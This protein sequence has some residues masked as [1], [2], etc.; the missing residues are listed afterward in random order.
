[1]LSRQSKFVQRTSRLDGFTFLSLVVFNSDSLA[2]ESLNDL[3]TK[4]ELDHGVE[5]TKQALDERFNKYAVNFLKT[6]L[7]KLLQKQLSA[8][9]SLIKCKEFKRIL[10]KDSVC[11][12]VDESMADTYPGSGGSGS[13]AN[14][15][16]QLEYDLLTGKVVDL[17]LNA[18]N[19]QDSVN[20]ML[21]IDV[22][23]D[24]DLIVR[25]LAYMHLKALKKILIRL[26][27]FL[28]RLQTQRKVYQQQ[29]NQLI[30]LDFAE[31]SRNMRAFDIQR[32]E[33]SVFLGED[34]ELQVRLFIYL[35]PDAVYR[36]RMRKLN[37]NAKK[38]GREL[39]A[40]SKARAQLTLFI[41]SAP[42]EAIS[43][44]TA[45]KVYTLRW[46]IELTFKVWKSIWKIDKVKKVKQERLE[47]YIWAKLFIIITSWHV[48]WFIGKMLRQLYG[49]NLS[50]YKAM[51]TIVFYINR[52]RQMI[53]GGSVTT[54]KYLAEF[55]ILS[56]RKHLLEK[57]K[58]ANYSPE[59]LF[60]TFTVSCVG[61]VISV[62]D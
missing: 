30:E 52:F 42:E 40:E 8:P 9:K 44:G 7:E 32:I 58:S 56:R 17:S 49:K 55:L 24:G 4:L 19:D 13:R 50:Y 10:I 48:L 60:G 36:E 34:L 39:T 46:Q 59:I 25:D 43:I 35:L 47:C 23:N 16:I 61:N 26:G 33:E 12:Q 53:I 37:R 5:I 3:S 31:I 57:K 14:V 22:V 15:R 11:F 41:T 2:Y 6:A 28:C 62:E 38:Q 27:H 18:F 51:K 45:W 29:G 20:S 21:T 54:G 1:M